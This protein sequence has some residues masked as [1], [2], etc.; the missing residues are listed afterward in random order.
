MLAHTAR[1]HTPI[2]TTI[3]VAAA[4][5][6]DGIERG[7]RQ[8]HNVNRSLECVRARLSV[9]A[10]PCTAHSTRFACVSECSAAAQGGHNEAV[11]CWCLSSNEPLCSSFAWVCACV[12]ECTLWRTH[13]IESSHS[14]RHLRRL[15][16]YGVLRKIEVTKSS[17]LR[18]VHTECVNEPIKYGGTV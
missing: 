15:R 2:T 4:A 5:A 17:L 14:L 16:V 3:A 11:C 13:C 18:V 10:M 12:A 9:F 8:K 7:K 6:N 1:A